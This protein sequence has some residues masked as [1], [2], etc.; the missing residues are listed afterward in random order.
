[1]D[2]LA[3]IEYHRQNSV[4]ADLFHRFMTQHYSE[5]DLTFFLFERSLAERELSLKLSHMP[6]NFDIRKQM[7]GAQRMQKIAKVYFQNISQTDEQESKVIDNL[8]SH[9]MS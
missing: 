9:F 8:T 3:S 2:F 1:M 7:I 4:E 6:N 5:Q